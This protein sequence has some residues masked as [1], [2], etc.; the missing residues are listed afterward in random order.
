[1]KKIKHWLETNFE[2]ENLNEKMENKYSHFQR[3]FQKKKNMK[4]SKEHRTTLGE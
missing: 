4:M 3:T 2:A 1:M